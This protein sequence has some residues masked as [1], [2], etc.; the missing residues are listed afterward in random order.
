[1]KKVKMNLKNLNKANIALTVASFGIAMLSSVV[2]NKIA[3]K[4]LEQKV[5]ERINRKLSGI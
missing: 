1:M 3:E 2:N 4:T 5:T